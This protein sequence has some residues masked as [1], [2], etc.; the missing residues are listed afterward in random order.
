MGGAIGKLVDRRGENVLGKGRHHA[1]GIRKFKFKFKFK[2]KFELIK[3]EFKFQLKFQLKFK[4]K[5]KSKFK[6]KFKFKFKFKFELKFSELDPSSN[7]V[8]SGF[9]RRQKGV[10]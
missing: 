7:S 4:C 3:L 9:Y 10:K 2:L 1:A 6:S 5:L 8:T